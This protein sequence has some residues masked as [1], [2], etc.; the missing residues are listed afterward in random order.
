MCPF[1]RRLAKIADAKRLFL[2]KRWAGQALML[3][4]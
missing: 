3:P 1:A 2:L 4:G